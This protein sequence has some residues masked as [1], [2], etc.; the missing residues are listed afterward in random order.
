LEEVVE[1]GRR[2]HMGR[3]EEEVRRAVGAR[4]CGWGGVVAR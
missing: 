3:V 1:E 2:R 4:V